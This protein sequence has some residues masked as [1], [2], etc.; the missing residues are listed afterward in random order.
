M[1]GPAQ[2]AL[3]TDLIPP[4]DRGKVLGFIATIAVSSGLPAPVIGGYLYQGNPDYPFLTSF[5]I[6]LIPIIVFYFFVKEKKRE[7]ARVTV[8]H[9]CM[10]SVKQ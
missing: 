2:Q 9:A 7:S 10:E 3:K 4:K 5:F 6:G 1:E 8:A